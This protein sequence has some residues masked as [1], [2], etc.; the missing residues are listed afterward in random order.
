MGGPA[1]TL[2]QLFITIGIFLGYL[3]NYAA[4]DSGFHD[5]GWRIVIAFPILPALL[6]LH[7]AKNVFP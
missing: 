4:L 3:F 5:L 7:T 1:G 2:N 6:R